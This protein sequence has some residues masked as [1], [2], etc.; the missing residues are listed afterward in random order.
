MYL[1]AADS[2]WQQWVMAYDLGHQAALAAKFEGTLRTLSEAR[3]RGKG[4]WKTGIWSGFRA[5]SAWAFGIA[6]LAG[7]ALLFAPRLGKDLRRRLKLRRIARRGGSAHD[8]SVL[9][10]AMLDSLA[11][12][13]FQKP[14]WF[15]PLEFARTL[16]AAESEPVTRFT[17]LYYSVRFG[18]NAAAA[19]TMAEML[20]EFKR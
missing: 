10:A 12:R 6:L 9:Y 3:L 7:L 20:R 16:P 15:T 2:M 18:G 4:D 13:G 11:R 8:A 19:V 5:W 1:D 14:V 17:S